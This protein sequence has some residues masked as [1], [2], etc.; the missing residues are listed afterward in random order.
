MVGYCF[1]FYFS[2]E[3]SWINSVDI[4]CSSS[5]SWFFLFAHFVF[6]IPFPTTCVL[7][8]RLR[9][10]RN[11]SKHDDKHRHWTPHT[12]TDR[13]DKRNNEPTHTYHSHGH[14]IDIPCRVASL[15]D[16]DTCFGGIGCS[17]RRCDA[18]FTVFDWAV[19]NW[20]RW[21]RWCWWCG[22]ERCCAVYCT[23]CV[24]Y[25]AFGRRRGCVWTCT[26]SS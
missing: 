5:S 21:W 16:N 4:A 24:G 9:F 7:E 18:A 8:S 14:T 6:F 12:R 11:S 19:E 15:D 10:T 22:V 17:E 3:S 20:F 2:T 26:R 13:F 1:Q 25:D 23:W